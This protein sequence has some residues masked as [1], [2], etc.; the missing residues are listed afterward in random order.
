MKQNF[1]RH[2][3]KDDCKLITFIIKWLIT[4]YTDCYQQGIEELIPEYDK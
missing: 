2:R 4:Q 1:G 3:F